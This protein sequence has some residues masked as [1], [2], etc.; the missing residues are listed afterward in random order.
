MTKPFP[1]THSILDSNALAAEVKSVYSIDAIRDI[2]FFTL[3]LNDTYLI[4]TISE[5]SYILRVYRA[6]WRS[7]SEIQFEI[8]LLN[9]LDQQGIS[10]SKP[11]QLKNGRF[12]HPIP[13]LEGTRYAVLFTYAAGKEPSYEKDFEATAYKY[14]KTAAQIHNATQDFASPHQRFRLDLSHLL[15]QP[16]QS[17]QPFL[18]QRQAD[19]VYLQELA[20]KTRAQM[21]S[22]PLEALEWGFCHGDLHGG[23]AHVTTNGTLTFFDFDCGGW[24]WLAYDI[25]VFRWHARIKEKENEHWQPF[26]RGYQEERI[27]NSVDLQATALF[28]GIR[29]YWLMGL[30]TRNS[31][32]FGHDWMNDR[33]FDQAL[34]FLKSWENEHLMG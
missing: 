23:N 2:K 14:G 33:Y 21:S 30:H 6:N 8:D 12:L 27:L 16:L 9:H 20:D 22:L 34:K 25:A 24:G 31:P 7:Y 4:K 15:D 29:H 28:V 19:W 10:V 11:M 3:G 26:L 13:A 1:V 18:L 32:H 5:E 17:I